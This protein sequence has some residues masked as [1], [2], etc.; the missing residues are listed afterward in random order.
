MRLIFLIGLIL[1]VADIGVAAWVLISHFAGKA[2]SGWSSLMLSVWFLG[3]L[4]LISL[5]IIGEYVGKIFNEVK[6][7]PRYSIQD[8]LL[9]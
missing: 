1:L 9:N 2:M 4:M 3:S 8:E 5:G 7:R 6:R